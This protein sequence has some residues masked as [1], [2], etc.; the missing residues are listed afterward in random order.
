M[1]A[2]GD[3]EREFHR[4]VNEIPML[5]LGLSVDVYSPDL[6]ELMGRFEGR[7][8][9][10]AYLEIFRAARAALQTVRQHAPAMP[11]AYHGEGLWV[12]QP[13]FCAAPFF[14]EEMTEVAGQLAMLRS[15]W[16]NHEC[17][18]KQMSGY[19]FGTYLPPLYTEESA[20]VVARNITLVQTSLDQACQASA[21][22]GPLFLLEVAPLTYFMAGTISVPRFFRLVTE[23]VPC[24]VVLDIG[25]LWTI[26]RYTSARRQESLARFVDRFLDEFPLERVVEIHVAGLAPHASSSGTSPQRPDANWVDAHAAPIPAV[27]WELCDRVLAHPRLANL[28]GVALEVDTKPIDLIVDEFDDANL[29]LGPTIAGRIAAAASTACRGVWRPAPCAESKQAS[30]EDRQRLYDDYVRYAKIASGQQAPAGPQWQGVLED[31]AGLGRYVHEYLP[32]EILHWGGAIAEMFPESCGALA[33]AGVSLEEFMPWWFRSSRPVERP[34]D[35]FLLKIDRFLD[36]VGERAP[37]LSPVARREAELLRRA[38]AEANEAI[39][40]AMEPAT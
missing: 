5:G 32:H 11:M 23:L 40:P 29:R 3:T 8:S 18:T 6:L 28:R 13:E 39:R 19:S 31:P 22:F 34:Y 37:A 35:F 7:K 9:R 15:P 27:S 30:Q 36:F 25:H 20:K 1:E 14:N 33:E 21:S 24:G 16:L 10:P 12:T 38:Y 2:F 17:A 4:R 26:Y